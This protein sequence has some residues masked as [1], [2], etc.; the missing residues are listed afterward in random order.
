MFCVILNSI[1]KKG[2]S[3]LGDAGSHCFTLILY[4]IEEAYGMMSG[5][6]SHDV[7]SVVS[8]HYFL[9][10]VA[11]TISICGMNNT[12][13]R[14]AWRPKSGIKYKAKTGKSIRSEKQNKKERDHTSYEAAP[15]VF[16]QEFFCFLYKK[17]QRSKYLCI[18]GMIS[19]N[20]LPPVL[21][22]L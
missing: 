13:W 15:A 21:I 18:H 3:R 9:H 6:G 11:L 7:R 4:R 10:D 17:G 19:N 8:E 16:L 1:Y 22:A 12:N 2:Y 20:I 5:R 14:F